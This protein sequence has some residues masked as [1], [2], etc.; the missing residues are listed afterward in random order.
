MSSIR[1]GRA[2]HRDA[3]AFAKAFGPVPVPIGSPLA[4]IAGRVGASSMPN[5]QAR[6]S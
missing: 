4:T 5:Q 3:A 6:D 2:S 1:R